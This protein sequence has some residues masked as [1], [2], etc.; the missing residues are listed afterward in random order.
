MI[1]EALGSAGLGLLLAWT[2]LHRLSHR[3]PARALVLST[4]VAGA[5]FGDFVARTALG[6]GHVLLSLLGA[7][8]VSVASLSLLLRPTG[9]LRRRSVT[10]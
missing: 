3:L 7:L 2:A 10:A 9:R 1:V 8:V 4:G 6:P 5:L